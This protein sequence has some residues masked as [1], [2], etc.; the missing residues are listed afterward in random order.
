MRLATTL[1]PGTRP[2][3]SFFFFK[4][5]FIRER[6]QMHKQGEGQRERDADSPLSREPYAGLDPRTP[7]S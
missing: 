7:G 4:I 1:R 2:Q 5:L 6:A 3:F